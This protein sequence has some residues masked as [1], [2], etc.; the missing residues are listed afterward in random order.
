MI[1][2]P[3]TE[4]PIVYYAHSEIHTEWFPFENWSLDFWFIERSVS[5]LKLHILLWVSD[6]N[7]VPDSKQVHTR[8]GRAYTYGRDTT[9]R[10]PT[11]PLPPISRHVQMETR[12]GRTIHIIGDASSATPFQML[13]KIAYVES[14]DTRQCREY[15][16][17]KFRAGFMAFL[18]LVG[19]TR[20]TRGMALGRICLE[21]MQIFYFCYF[22]TYSWNLKQPANHALSNTP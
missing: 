19:G 20:G 6:R 2:P 12:T 15:L 1:K 18:S 9:R 21:K 17:L 3:W 13:L 22:E 5:S 4:K 7:A 8:R 16:P 11:M 14:A 10:P